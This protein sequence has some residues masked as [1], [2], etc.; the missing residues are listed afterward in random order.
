MDA[1]TAVLIGVTGGLG[2]ALAR[3]LAAEGF[4]MVLAARREH[5][6]AALTGRSDGSAIYLRADVTDPA[7]LEKLAA[8]ASSTSAGSMRW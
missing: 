1:P 8:A 5:D 2:H 6:A 4:R 7:S 3:L